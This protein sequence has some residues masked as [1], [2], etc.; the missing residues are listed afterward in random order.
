MS[1]ISRHDIITLLSQAEESIPRQ[2]LGHGSLRLTALRS[3]IVKLL[4][5]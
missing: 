5:V 1:K 4:M 3:C 2:L